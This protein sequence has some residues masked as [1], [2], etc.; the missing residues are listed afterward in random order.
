MNSDHISSDISGLHKEAAPYV[1][2]KNYHKAAQLYE[3][4]INVNPNC[5]LN[6]WQ[7]GLIL[8][9][10]GR[11]EEAQATWLF[12]MSDGTPEQ[13]DRWNLELFQVLDTEAHQ[14][15][16]LEN[17]SEAW[18]IRQHMREI[19][20]S[21]L[22]NI[23]NLIDLS[24]TIKTYT[25][26]Q[27]NEY[28][29]IT[30]LQQ[31][32]V[33]VDFNLILH[34]LKKLLINDQVN[35]LCLEFA[36]FVVSKYQNFPEKGRDFVT[37]CIPI[38]YDIAYSFNKL[39]IAKSY[40]ELFLDLAPEHGEILRLLS[41]C[42]INLMQYRQGIEYAK[43]CYAIAQTED[44]KVYRNHLILRALMAE[45]GC[46][47]EVQKAIKNQELLLDSLF[48]NFPKNLKKSAIQLYSTT[49]YF[50]YVRDLPAENSILKAKVS[51]ICQTN[52]EANN[53]DKIAQYK[54][55]IFKRQPQI[56]L[57]KTLKIG[58]VSYGLR[59]HSV[60]WISRWLFKY[61][62]REKFKIYAYL[63]GAKNRQDSLQNWYVKQ[64]HQSY[65]Y[66]IVSTEVADQISQDEIDILID[67]DSLTLTNTCAIMALKPAPVQVTWL[68]WD[69]SAIPTIDYFIADPYV[70]PENAQDYYPETIWRL[71]QTYVAVDGFEVGIS[72]LRR[73]DLN[74]TDN[75]IIYFSA[76]RG[77]KY[78]PEMAKL[79]IQIIKEVPNSYLVIKGFGEQE[80]ITG[81]FL[82]LAE[83][84]GIGQERLRFIS[85][86]SL[87]H[88]HRANLAI[89]DVVL[90]TYPY[91]GATTTLET[92]W[93]GIPIVTKVGQQFAARN[94]YTMMINAGIT[95]GIAWNNEEYVEWGVRFGT[96]ENLRK[97]VSWKLQKS[98]QTAPLWNAEQFTKEMEKAYQ[99]MWKIYATGK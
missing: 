24:L 11:E 80:P 38:L 35:P 85:G 37:S 61:H 31:Q 28:G 3:Q 40:A 66:G 94:S 97:Q 32:P 12:A 21:D 39:E 92:L 81:L 18:T 78:N 9:L 69:G 88:T 17:Y 49:F 19:N 14:Q 13:I 30:L 91:N 63:I 16:S 6:Y 7:L 48:N 56:N 99:Q 53:A 90:D 15:V 87:E 33:N 1:K 96:D 44:Q 68:G 59:R 41:E 76:Q 36:Q 72:N 47:D 70:L 8:L 23:L 62:D 73:E 79:Q 64:A 98:K 57:T 34:I 25:D 89:A 20:P 10:Q 82:E 93:M 95:E 51:R 74:L 67:L 55:E 86:V 46:T 60:G 26:T 29:V 50:A 22:N 5:K 84:E 45:G 65:R 71:P 75:A 2:D 27:L 77:P 4:A 54:A 52:L 58:Y 83:A 43:R 42:C